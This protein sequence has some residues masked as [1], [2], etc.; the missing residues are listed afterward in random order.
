MAFSG[1]IGPQG[2]PL[3]R[4][5]TPLTQ[6]DVVILESTY[7]DRDHRPRQETIEELAAITG[8]ARGGTGKV[9]I[10]AFAVGRTQDLIYEFGK[11]NRAGRFKNRVFIDSPMATKATALYERN[12]KLLDAETW[13]IV[14]KGGDP[15]RFAGL[16]F[17]GTVEESKRLN[18][19][20]SGAVVVAGSGMCT[21]GRIVHHLKHDLPNPTTQVVIVGFQAVGTLGRRLVDGQKVVRIF[22]EET[23]VKA[24]VHT[25]GG[26]S[27]HAGQSGL[28]A[29]GANFK[30][31][32]PRLFLTHG[33]D[34]PRRALGGRLERELGYGPA[35]PAFGE[36]VE[37]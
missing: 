20:D 4:D 10:P 35:Y 17:V 25:L 30:G 5:P 23:P 2:A 32:R 22:G 8:A 24:A 31:A 21:G 37:L 16:E 7:G 29:W 34:G 9:L 27:A 26:L 3:V 19:I 14:S 1:D 6:A 12:C 15:L 28:F 13:A 36:A 11:L 33:E 18:D